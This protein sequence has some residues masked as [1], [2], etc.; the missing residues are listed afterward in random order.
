MAVSVGRNMDYGC[1]LTA[2]TA[3]WADTHSCRFAVQQI[4]LFKPEYSP[5]Q[6][7]EEQQQQQQG[8]LQSVSRAPRWL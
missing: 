3:V 5:P 7:Q 2:T 8:T 6:Q 1:L 4:S